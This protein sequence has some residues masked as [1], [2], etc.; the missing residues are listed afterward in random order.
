LCATTRSSWSIFNSEHAAMYT[1]LH[2]HPIHEI[3]HSAYQ[4]LRGAAPEWRDEN[5][6]ASGWR[7]TSRWNVEH[8]RRCRKRQQQ[9]QQG[10][11][12][13]I[14]KDGNDEERPQQWG[15]TAKTRKDSD[16]EERLFHWLI[17]HLYSFSHPSSFSW[18]S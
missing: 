3:R 5:G 4:Q 2:A 18:F 17:T 8:W 7:L 13:T 6:G 14:R 15:K 1:A 10:K 12:A 9:Q 16:N 11:T